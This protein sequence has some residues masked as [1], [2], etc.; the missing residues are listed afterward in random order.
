[1]NS[2]QG[3]T[4]LKVGDIFREYGEAYRSAHELPLPHLKVI[5][6]G[7]HIGS[8]LTALNPFED[9]ICKQ[10]QLLDQLWDRGFAIDH[11]D[12]GGGLGIRYE[13]EELP[14]IAAYA[15][16]IRRCVGDRKVRILMEPGRAIV[17]NAGLLLTRVEYVKQTPHKRFVIVDGAMNDLLR[18]ALYQAW[19]GIQPIKTTHEEPV[20]CDVVGPICETGDFLARG[21]ALAA[22]TGDLLAVMSAGAYGFSMSSNYN[23]RPRAAEVM[24]D[25]ASPYLVR[26][27]ELVAELMSGESPLPIG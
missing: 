14:P 26:R 3:T 16:T 11:L 20:A 8:Q 24:V 7:C 19:H 27:R 1:M 15:N 4:G 23:A 10:L 22:H 5:G 18:P 13:N 2:P 9:A 17:G 21:R 25:G 12:I 6:I